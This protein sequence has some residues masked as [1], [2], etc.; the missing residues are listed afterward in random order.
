MGSL[1]IWSHAD[2]S[3]STQIRQAL[4]G[5]QRKDRAHAL[6]AAAQGRRFGKKLE[7]KLASGA[8]STYSAAETDV[9]TEAFMSETDADLPRPAANSNVTNLPLWLPYHLVLVSRW[10]LFDLMLDHIKVHWARCSLL[11]LPNLLASA[12][13]CWCHSQHRNSQALTCYV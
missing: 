13:T 1:Q 11:V 12:D 2:K 3:R 9:E 5:S 4:E 6:K 8:Q 10:P 7:S